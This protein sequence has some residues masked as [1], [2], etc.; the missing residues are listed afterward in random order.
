MGGPSSEREVSLRTGG[1]VLQALK[2][3][4]YDA[5]AIDWTADRSLG[6]LVRTTRI[7]VAWIA[8]HGT[9]GEDGCVQGLLECE[10]IPYTGSGVLAS[11]LGMDKVQS[12]RLFDHFAIATPPWTLYGEPR[13]VDDLGFPLVVKPSREG[14]SV[15]VTIVQNAAQLSDGL[16]AAQ[17]CHG[18]ILLE[19]YIKGAD[20]SVAV[21]DD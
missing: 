21:L 16:A 19:R 7:E 6:E 2:N 15:G 18:E 1:A 5:V 8:L 14:S 9:W 13:D 11:A 3:R 4:G 12:K 17:K 10:R 20:L